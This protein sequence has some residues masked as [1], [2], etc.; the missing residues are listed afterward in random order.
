MTAYHDHKDKSQSPGP[1]KDEGPGKCPLYY[2][3]FSREMEPT[4]ERETK[5]ERE[6][7]IDTES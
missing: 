5:R 7:K 4:G 6:I 1:S 3:E 2:L